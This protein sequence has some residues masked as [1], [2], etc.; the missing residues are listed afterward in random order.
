MKRA[1]P[2]ML[3]RYHTTYC[4]KA[5]DLRDGKPVAHICYVLPVDALHAER[6]GRFEDA[7]TIIESKKPLRVSKGKKASR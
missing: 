6:D 1:T 5:H 2:N 4:N 7:I 3:V